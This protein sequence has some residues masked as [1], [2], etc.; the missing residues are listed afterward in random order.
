MTKLELDEKT[1]EVWRKIGKGM[2]DPKNFLEN[3]SLMKKR[4][5]NILKIF[6]TERVVYAGPECGLGGF[7]TYETAIEYLRR[8]ASVVKQF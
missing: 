4:L 7:P 1:A 5:E 6:G 8:V 3:E 2:L